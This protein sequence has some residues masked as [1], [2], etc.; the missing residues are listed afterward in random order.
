MRIR[1]L[2]PV[3]AALLT[4]AAAPTVAAAGP[5]APP[6]VGHLSGVWCTSSS[7]CIAVGGS[8]GAASDHSLAEQWN[9]LGWTALATPLHDTNRDLSAVACPGPKLCQAVGTVGAELW[10]GSG[11]ADETMPTGVLAPSFAAVSCPTASRCLA[12]GQRGTG[13]AVVTL[14]ETWN[15]SA[16]SVHNPVNPAG[17]LAASL[18]SVWCVSSSDC[19]AVGSYQPTSNTLAGLAESWNGSAWTLLPNPPG[20]A[21][22]IWCASASSCIAVGGDSAAS[23]NGS[24]WTALPKPPG[25]ANAI[26]C[27]TASRCMAV[28][29]A[30][31]ESWNGSAWKALHVPAPALSL[32]SVSCISASACVAVGTAADIGSFAMSWNGTA[33]LAHR[34]NKRDQLSG[35]SCTLA[36]RC[37]A[38]GSAVA[39]AVTWE[40]LAASWNGTSWRQRGTGAPPGASLSDVSCVSASDCMA[41]GSLAE[42]WN[43]TSWRITKSPGGQVTTVSCKG[44][45]CLAVGRSLVAE[46]WNGSSWRLLTVPLPSPFYSGELT[47]VSCATAT[48][49]LL[50]GFYYTSVQS[51]SASFADLWNGTKLRLLSAPGDGL[52]TV[53]CASTSFCMALTGSGAEIWNGK[54]WRT[55]AKFSGTFGFG[56]GI[57][58]VS[59]VSKSACLAV[60]N[61]L[62]S[63]GPQGV[64]GF[65]VAEWWNG[66]SWRR[67]DPAGAGGGLADVSCTSATRCMAVGLA[68]AGQV[69]EHTLAERWNGSGWQILGTPNP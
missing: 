48:Y 53:S 41:V 55:G 67:L 34:V 14:A 44:T 69:A 26:W 47:D 18:S 59:C 58:A 22:A 2:V 65:N 61:Y 50:T 45:D 21:N 24:A 35:V 32:N 1:Q 37:L 68:P 38:A 23:W 4:S 31:A 19:V 60:G 66:S 36:S 62:A 46:A 56:P 63:G 15:G 17:A 7:S 11:W 52:N 49:C 51:N 5:G 10:N 8:S 64:E 13:S 54:T 42:R 40:A 57:T 6:A 28:G 16:W 9:G 25:P 33:W 3:L 29:G 30:S 43:G 12:V 27:A 20:P 39:P